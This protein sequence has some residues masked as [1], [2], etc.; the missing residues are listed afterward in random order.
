MTLT[1]TN[2]KYSFAYV[3]AIIINIILAILVLCD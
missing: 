2:M 1:S 3:K